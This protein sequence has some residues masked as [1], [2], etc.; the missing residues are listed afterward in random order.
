M[1]SLFMCK[2]LF[3]KNIILSTINSINALT[4]CIFASVF[5]GF[6]VDKIKV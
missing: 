3:Y 4:S 6:M 5:T 2:M 1:P